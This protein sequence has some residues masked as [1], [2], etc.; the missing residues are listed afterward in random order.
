[1]NTNSPEVSVIIPSYNHAQYIAEAIDSVLAQT[2]KDLEIIVIDDGSTD[3]TASVLKSYVDN[4]QIVYIY[5]A[6]KGPSAARNAGL[7]LA[8]GRY[9]KFLDGDDYLYPE[10][11]ARQIRDI[12][13]E[14]DAISVTDCDILKPSGIIEVRKAHLVSREK[15]L[16]AFIES[17]RVV[18]HAVLLPKFLLDGVG[19]FDESLTCSVDTDLWIRILGVGVYMKHLPYVGCCY[20]ILRKSV[21]DNTENMFFQKVKIYEKLNHTFLAEDITNAFL[22][23]SLLSVNTKLLEEGVARKMD[24][25]QK[26]PNTMAMT[27]KLYL[28][29][30]KGA[31]GLLYRAVGVWNYLKLRYIFRRLTNKDY[32]FNLLYHN[33]KWRY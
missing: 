7:R 30:L 3:Q 32:N 15:Q 22:I 25:R 1:M 9:V 4:G 33:Y 27:E 23:D 10:Q 29:R 21:S 14:P 5:Q 12:R 24:S 6:N 13:G 11:I 26:L 31:L 16:A 18:I 8:R 17:N 19:G 28:F 20:R 2:F